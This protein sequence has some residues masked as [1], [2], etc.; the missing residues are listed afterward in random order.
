[1]ASQNI[2]KIDATRLPQ[3]GISRLYNNYF[4]GVMKTKII[5]LVLFL[6]L[7]STISFAQ[8]KKVD[9]LFSAMKEHNSKGTTLIKSGDKKAGLNELY[10][11]VEDFRDYDYEL[12]DKRDSLKLL[13]KIFWMLI[14][15]T[16]YIIIY[17]E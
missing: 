16:S 12:I 11:S 6:L 10:Q 5:S 2:K 15:Q 13:L 8:N 7:L 3:A 1:M 14:P 4:R 9:S 17:M